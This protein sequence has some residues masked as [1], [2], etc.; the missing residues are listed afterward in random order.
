[1][2]GD[3]PVCFDL[4]GV[5]TQHRHQGASPANDLLVRG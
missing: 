3:T 2:V 4:M 5:F 1:M